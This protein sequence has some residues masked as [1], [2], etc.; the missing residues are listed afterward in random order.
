MPKPPNCHPCL[1]LAR[2]AAITLAR[3]AL[4][5]ALTVALR[6]LWP[7]VGMGMRFER[8]RLAVRT[9]IA[10]SRARATRGIV[11]RLGIAA[12]CA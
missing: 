1:V 6:R 10:R 5:I 2:A 8:A 4:A 9:T 7:S 3:A 12:D 11:E